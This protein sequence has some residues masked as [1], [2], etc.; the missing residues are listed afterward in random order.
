LFVCFVVEASV[1]KRGILA[2]FLFQFN[3]SS[4]SCKL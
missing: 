3:R 1:G 4:C 2:S